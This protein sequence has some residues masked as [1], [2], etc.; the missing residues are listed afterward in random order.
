MK[1]PHAGI[2]IS[3]RTYTKKMSFFTAQKKKREG[4]LSA[5]E[6]SRAMG[7]KLLASIQ[8][9]FIRGIASSKKGLDFVPL[10]ANVESG[11][12]DFLHI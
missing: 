4:F 2:K 1:L 6:F 9:L 11:S 12:F 7:K 3:A 10:G 8:I 5:E